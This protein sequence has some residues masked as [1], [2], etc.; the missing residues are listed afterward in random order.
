[1]SPVYAAVSQPSPRT[2]ARAAVG[3]RLCSDCLFEELP[4]RNASRLG[5]DG[6]HR[7]RPHD[8]K[9]LHG[10]NPMYWPVGLVPAV[11]IP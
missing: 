7:C 8:S 11:M 4:L 5:S 9:W 10:L 2:S 1:M 3:V 6:V